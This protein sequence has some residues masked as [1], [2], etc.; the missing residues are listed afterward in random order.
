MRAV[1][2]DVVLLLVGAFVLDLEGVNVG[3]GDLGKQDDEILL[4]A[5]MV[6]DTSGGS[7]GGGEGG[8]QRRRRQRCWRQRRGQ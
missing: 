2:Q 8:E 5:K 3:F 1:F 6:F 7:W 4:Q